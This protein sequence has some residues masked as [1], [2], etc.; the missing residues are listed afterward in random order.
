M[1]NRAD[2]TGYYTIPSN[3]SRILVSRRLN[4]EYDDRR[5]YS[6]DI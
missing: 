1:A 2:T 6:D 3:P 5:G 4:K